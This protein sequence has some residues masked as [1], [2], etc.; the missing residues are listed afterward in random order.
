VVAPRRKFIP[1]FKAPLPGQGETS[2]GTPVTPASSIT[3]GD[4]SSQRPQSLRSVSVNG[5]FSNDVQTLHTK[6]FNIKYWLSENVRANIEVQRLSSSLDDRALH[7]AEDHMHEQ[8]PQDEL[9]PAYTETVNDEEPS[10]D[11][12]GP[13]INVVMH[14]VGSQLEVA[15][16]IEV[17]QR[18]QSA[19]GHRVR[20]ATHPEFKMDVEVAGIEYFD[21][22]VPSR[23]FGVF[24]GQ[25]DHPA[26]DQGSSWSKESA[27]TAGQ[28]IPQLLKACWQSCVSPS[29]NGRSFAADAIIANPQSCAHMHCAERLGVP[30][31]LMSASVRPMNDYREPLQKIDANRE[32]H[33]LDPYS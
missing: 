27:A 17:A 13:F 4:R 6:E 26:Q 5:N 15:H 1:D 25:E 33:A 12:S 28:L 8:P 24:S 3:V 32:Q 18:L 16:F 30:L 29:T 20:L 14:V 2:T 11:Y 22:K 23:A 7:D 9:P 31:H 10:I 21:L 19:Y